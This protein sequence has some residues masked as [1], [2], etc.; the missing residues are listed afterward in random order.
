MFRYIKSSD[1][2]NDLSEESV[3]DACYEEAI[4]GVIDYIEAGDAWSYDDVVSEAYA[5]IQD[6]F[7]R[8][9]AVLTDEVEDKIYEDVMYGLQD[10]GF[11]DHKQGLLTWE[12]DE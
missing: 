4:Q 1:V 8:T 7:D 9:H 3:Y 11:I 12:G 5:Q 6:Y 10:L 2:F